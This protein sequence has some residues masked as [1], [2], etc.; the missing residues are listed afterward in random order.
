MP[1]LEMLPI[2]RKRLRSP[3]DVLKLLLHPDLKSSRFVATKMPTMIC[4]GA[5]F[6]VNIDHLDVPEDV[7]CD[8]MGVWKNNGT[9]KTYMNVKFES[10][11]VSKVMKYSL[12]DAKLANTYM[13]KRV[14][15][16]HGMNQSLRKITALIYGMFIIHKQTGGGRVGQAR[17]N[18]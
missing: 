2:E 16:T 4:N 10:S 7:L 17:V 1:I 14:Y 13:V 3:E 5:S 6:V 18:W 9:D 11:A 8:G 12:K 15:R